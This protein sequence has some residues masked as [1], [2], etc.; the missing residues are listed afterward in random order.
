M[1]QIHAARKK[2]MKRVSA[3]FTEALPTHSMMQLGPLTL[4]NLKQFI[5]A[6]LPVMFSASRKNDKHL[7]EWLSEVSD[8]HQGHTHI[9]HGLRE[10]CY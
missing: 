7:Y 4:S 2:S 6:K 3:S 9:Y 10:D 1:E 8:T 5:E